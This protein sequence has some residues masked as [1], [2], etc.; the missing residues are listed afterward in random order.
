MATAEIFQYP[1]IPQAPVPVWDGIDFAE[2]EEGPSLS[3]IP[4]L[5]A[6]QKTAEGP[7][8]RSEMELRE[9]A[10]AGFE[11]ARLQ[12]IQEGRQIEQKAQKDARSAADAE[13][14]ERAAA[15]AVEFAREIDQYS[16]RVEPEVVGLAL[17]IAARILRREAQMDPL[18]LTG[19]VRVAL[20]QLSKSTKVRLRVPATDL[21]LWSE[22]MAHMPNL[23]ARPEVVPGEAMR[24]GECV[25]E[26]EIGSVNLGIRAQL[27]EIERGFFD[28]AGVGGAG[29]S[30]GLQEEYR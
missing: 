4:S 16:L 13:R 1:L 2:R 10:K 25:V 7:T 9:D 23:A 21:D 15:L 20:G 22:A 27:D 6:A 14:F 28:G 26:T 24:T 5:A 19:A 8:P 29:N 30:L 3:P 17:A 18:M 12:G 11:T